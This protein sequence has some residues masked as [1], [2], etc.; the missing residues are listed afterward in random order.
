MRWQRFSPFRSYIAA[1]AGRHRGEIVPIWLIVGIGRRRGVRLAEGHAV[2]INNALAQMNA[3]TRK[4]DHALDQEQVLA[5]GLERGLIKNDDVPVL[6]VAV[7]NKGSP[8]RRRR[9]R[10]AIHQDVIRSEEHTS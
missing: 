1:L 10:N 7:I 4:A 2:A 6:H 9:K 3:V 8:R 5:V